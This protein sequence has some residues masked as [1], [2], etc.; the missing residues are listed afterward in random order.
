MVGEAAAELLDNR[1]TR[2]VVPDLPL[3]LRPPTFADAYAIQALVVDALTAQAPTCR[4]SR[5][6]TTSPA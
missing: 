5:R 2:R 3:S 1:R 4:S 6:T